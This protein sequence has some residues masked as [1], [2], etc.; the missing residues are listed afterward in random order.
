MS[1]GLVL[2]SILSMSLAFASPV[3][4]D[5][6]SMVASYEVSVDKE[7]NIVAFNVT[8]LSAHVAYAAKQLPDKPKSTVV[9][10]DGLFTANLKAGA[11]IGATHTTEVGWRTYSLV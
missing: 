1:V 4:V 8:D 11:F 5:T 6:P 3:P 2:A 9:Y 10:T 7:T